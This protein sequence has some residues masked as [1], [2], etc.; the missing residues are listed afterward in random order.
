MKEWALG[1]RL[2]NPVKFLPI[3]R[4]WWF[5]RSLWG[6]SI[7]LFNECTLGIFDIGCLEITAYEKYS[8]SCGI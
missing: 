2:V 4:D 3:L 6:P 7:E 8:N 5:S 1:I